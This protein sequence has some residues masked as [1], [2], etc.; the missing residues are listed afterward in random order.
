MGA[1]INF[2]KFKPL[3]I[4]LKCS[5]PLGTFEKDHDIGHLCGQK[6]EHRCNNQCPECDA[7]C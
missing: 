6:K 3:K 5:I 7:Y 1:I 2:V 4:R